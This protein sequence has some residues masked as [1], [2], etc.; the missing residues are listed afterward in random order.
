MGENVRLGQSSF[1]Q[2]GLTKPEALFRD[3]ECLHSGS[4]LCLSG[5][6]ALV[7][8]ADDSFSAPNVQVKS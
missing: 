2:T 1:A 5:F 4:E 8:S 3:N 6:G 7:S